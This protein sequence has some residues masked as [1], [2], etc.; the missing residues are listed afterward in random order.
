M[1]SFLADASTV[2]LVAGAGKG[3]VEGGGDALL[4]FAE[5]LD[6]ADSLGLLFHRL[7]FNGI[8]RNVPLLERDSGN[9]Y[10][11]V[12]VFSSPLSSPFLLHYGLRHLNLL[13]DHNGE[14]LSAW[15]DSFN[16]FTFLNGLIDELGHGD[17]LGLSAE[18]GDLAGNVHG[19]DADDLLHVGL[20]LPNGLLDAAVLVFGVHVAVLVLVL[21]VDVVLEKHVLLFA[22]AG[23][24][25][26]SFASLIAVAAAWLGRGGRWGGAAVQEEGFIVHG[27]RS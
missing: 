17:H 11:F 22:A 9:I 3:D 10:G 13:V 23:G 7:I 26:G 5:L 6:H 18:D 8:S 19:T 2:L 15:N 20:L 25:T 24:A 1:A 27:P 21:L 4:D 16:D 14:N 12:F